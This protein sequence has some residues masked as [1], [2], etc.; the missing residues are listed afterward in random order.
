MFPPSGS[1]SHQSTAQAHTWTFVRLTETTGPESCM[2][3][4]QFA[5]LDPFYTKLF[6]IAQFSLIMRC[7]KLLV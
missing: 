5:T 6:R 4:A 2:Q 7:H 1:V 3:A